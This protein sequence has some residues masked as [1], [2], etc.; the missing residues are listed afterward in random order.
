MVAIM[1]VGAL[2]TISEPS[3]QVK[4]TIVA[5]VT[6]FGCGFIFAWAPL[7]YVVTT[8][9]P[10]L[11]LRDVSQ[12]TASIVN[13]IFQ[14][15]VNFSIPYL[16]Y[17]PYANL[18]SKLGFVFGSFSFCAVIFTY[19][20]VPE[21]KGKT[22]EQLDLLFHQG[23]PLRKFGSHSFGATEGDAEDT[24]GEILMETDIKHV[25]KV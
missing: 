19:F 15:L 18:G 24:K 12:R 23:V 17:A 14:F 13:V 5:M 25:E 1:T 6:V 16:L 11:R 9:V 7:T 21:C 8:E 4:T 10:A 2:G 22:L 3:Y 20:C